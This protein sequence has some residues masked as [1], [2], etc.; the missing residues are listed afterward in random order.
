MSAERCDTR[1]E[2]MVE[3]AA[4]SERDTLVVLD[5]GETLG[6]IHFDRQL[7]SWLA[8]ADGQSRACSSV[9]SAVRFVET[10]W[11][12]ETEVRVLHS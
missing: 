11:Q 5:H 8:S 1:E 3:V 12:P 2:P 10:V 4:T 7:R 9:A 6:T